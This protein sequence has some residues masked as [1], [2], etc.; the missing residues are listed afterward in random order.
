MRKF[1]PYLLVFLLL[2]CCALS[3][4]L[5][6]SAVP[7]RETEF[8][9]YTCSLQE[10]DTWI[11]TAYR[12]KEA[13]LVIPSELDGIAVTA[14]G[15]SA[16]VGNHDITDVT[17]PEGIV[18]LG[19]YAFQRCDSLVDHSVAVRLSCAALFGVDA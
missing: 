11:I 5:A 17:V 2:L 6:E 15:P 18:S 8:G 14:I 19:D 13:T 1:I 10:D 7:G 3:S 16:F 12:G 4:A 9:N